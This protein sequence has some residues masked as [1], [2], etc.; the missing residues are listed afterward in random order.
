MITPRTRL[1]L[2]I[3][4]TQ[5]STPADLKALMSAV[6]QETKDH[7][8]DS[9]K[10]VHIFEQKVPIPSYLIAIVV[11]ALESRLVHINLYLICINVI[12]IT[13]SAFHL[14]TLI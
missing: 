9:A 8:T 4:Y 5:I 10:K 12:E 2:F 7:Q 13:S 1:H 6:G 11:G 14:N 3:L